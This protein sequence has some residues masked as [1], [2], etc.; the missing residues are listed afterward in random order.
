VSD[1]APLLSIVLPSYQGGASLRSQLPDFLAWL[2]AQSWTSEI[3][4][5]DDGSDDQ[6]LTETVARENG[7]RFLRHDVNQGK[8]AAVRKGMLAATGQYRL[9]TDADIPFEFDAVERFLTYLQD[10]EFDLVVGDR[11]L[12]QSLYFAEITE[13][14]K[15]GSRLFSFLVGRFVTTGLFDTQCGMK[16]FSAQVARDL[17][18][19]ARV[20][21][22]AFDVELLYISLKRNYD[23]KRLP[24][25]IRRNRE[26]SSVS[27]LRHAPGM[28]LDLLRLKW[29]H[30]LGYYNEKAQP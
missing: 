28:V 8:G 12:K 20:D 1:S 23:I 18:S 14:R 10:K 11:T 3:V 16:G 4:V 17:F 2:R 29:N 30:V 7:C 13:T 5:V 9:F 26:L 6:G 15:L 22:F 19:V 24:V 25:R 27:L 21:G